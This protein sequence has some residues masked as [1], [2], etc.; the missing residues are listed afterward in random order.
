MLRQTA[1][2]DERNGKADVL[3]GRPLIDQSIIITRKALMQSIKGRRQNNL[4]QIC[5]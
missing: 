2:L 1:P 5:T 4:I 3:Q